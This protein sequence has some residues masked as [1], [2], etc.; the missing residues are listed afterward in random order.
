[1]SDFYTVTVRKAK[2]EHKCGL[3]CRTIAKGERYQYESGN[4]E[5][6]MYNNKTCADCVPVQQAFFDR[7]KD[8]LDGYT[9]ENI[10]DDMNE[11]VC[12]DCRKENGDC[13]HDYFNTAQC[14]K[15]R[16]LYVEAAKI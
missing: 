1:M 12:Y 2:K 6:E 16:K 13:D 3:C 7:R 5:G 11:V 9:A 15:A 4:Y 10:L 8:L 14:E